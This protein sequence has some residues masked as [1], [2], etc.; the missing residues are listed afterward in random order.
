MT[1]NE[2]DEMRR[3]ITFQFANHE[4]AQNSYTNAQNIS[5]ISRKICEFA[6]YLYSLNFSNEE[7]EK[8][9]DRCVGELLQLALHKNK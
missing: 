3:R 5:P 9:K 1:D 2:F 7:D 6:L 4:V 8:V